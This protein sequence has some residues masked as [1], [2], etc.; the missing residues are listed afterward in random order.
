MNHK[1]YFKGCKCYNKAHLD[2]QIEFSTVTQSTW[3][4]SFGLELE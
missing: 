4:L 3:S 1:D 2:Y